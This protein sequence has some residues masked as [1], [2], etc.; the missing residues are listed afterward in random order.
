MPWKLMCGWMREWVNGWMDGWRGDGMPHFHHQC[1][2]NM[3][4]LS[5]GRQESHTPSSPT[6]AYLFLRSIVPFFHWEYNTFQLPKWV[7]AVFLV[8]YLILEAWESEQMLVTNK[9]M[10][11]H[12]YSFPEKDKLKVLCFSWYCYVDGGSYCYAAMQHKK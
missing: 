3:Y 7:G 11:I 9:L 10:K 12:H 4:T 5:K 2:S 1:S 8:G 6:K